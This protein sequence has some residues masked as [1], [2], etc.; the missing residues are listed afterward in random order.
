M[1]KVLFGEA[2]DVYLMRYQHWAHG[3]LSKSCIANYV[4]AQLSKMG[5]KLVL[6]R[7]KRASVSFLF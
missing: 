6:S 2:Q 1:E 3:S 4:T 5:T 7:A